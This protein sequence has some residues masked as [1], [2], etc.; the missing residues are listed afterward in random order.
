MSLPPPVE[1]A[2]CG[3]R[4]SVLKKLCISFLLA[5]PRVVRLRLIAGLGNSDTPLTFSPCPPLAPVLPH[6]PPPF[7]ALRGKQ[8][9]ISWSFARSHGDMQGLPLPG[10]IELFASAS[11]SAS[12]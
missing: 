1:V 11:T 3:S 12:T 10:L 9:R 2:I 7:G 4:G 8:V 6:Q 5:P